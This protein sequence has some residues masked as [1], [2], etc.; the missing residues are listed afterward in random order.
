[1]RKIGL[2]ENKAMQAETPLSPGAEHPPAGARYK[3]PSTFDQKYLIL[4]IKNTQYFWPK[5]PSTFEQKY[6]V[7]L[8]I[9]T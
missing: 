4:L 1:M 2:R 5:I 6:L 9:N 7:F 8:G 3:I